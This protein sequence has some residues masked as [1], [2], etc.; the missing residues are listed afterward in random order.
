MWS[1]AFLT[2]T[3]ETGDQSVT[4]RVYIMCSLFVKNI[5]YRM[6]CFV[7]TVLQRFISYTLISHTNAHAVRGRPALNDGLSIHKLYS[8]KASQTCKVHS[9]F[10]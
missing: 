7:K 9:S 3:A 4:T 2:Q 8:L 6:L 1:Q 5:I 10:R